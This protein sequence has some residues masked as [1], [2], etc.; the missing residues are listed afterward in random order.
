MDESR[1]KFFRYC[2]GNYIMNHTLP[3]QLNY[4]PPSCKTPRNRL[5]MCAKHVL[6]KPVKGGN[7]SLSIG[8]P[9]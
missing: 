7:P 1:R 3:D 8:D 6:H 4:S 2:L 9:P 5:V